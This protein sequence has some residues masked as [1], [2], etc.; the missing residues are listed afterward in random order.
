ML[1][2][3]YRIRLPFVDVEKG[4]IGQLYTINAMSMENS[5]GGEGVELLHN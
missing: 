2:K 3:E 1:V 5:G 4:N